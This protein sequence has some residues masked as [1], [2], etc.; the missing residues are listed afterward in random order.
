MVTWCFSRKGVWLEE[1]KHTAYMSYVHQDCKS[2]RI[3]SPLYPKIIQK[4]HFVPKS[5]KAGSVLWSPYAYFSV[6]FVSEMVGGEK[7]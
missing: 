2:F 6:I 7:S 5:L 4:F 3:P 1:K